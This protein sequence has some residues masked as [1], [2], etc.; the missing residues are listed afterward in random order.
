MNIGKIKQNQNY[1]IFTIILLSWSHQWLSI[2]SFINVSYN[3]FSLSSVLA[4]RNQSLS[5]FVINIFI[6]ILN[7]KKNFEN[8]IYFY[9]FLIPITY[10][11]GLFNLYIDTPN[12]QNMEFFYHF[13]FILQMI[14]TLLILNN[15]SKI[16]GIDQ[17]I[18]LKVNLLLIFIYIIIIFTTYD[19]SNLTF[20]YHINFLNQKILTN[21][22]GVSRILSIIS[23]FI[24]CYYFI[25][26]KGA[27]LLLII[28]F[29]IINIES[30]QGTILII[31]QLFIIIFWYHKDE[32]IKK[33]LQY[34]F[35]L[36]IIPLGLSLFLK[37]NLQKNR[38]F[39]FQGDLKNIAVL[40]D[41]PQMHL[42][43][44]DLK[45]IEVLKDKSEVLK[46]KSQ[47][48]LDMVKFNIFTTGRLE[49]WDTALTHIINSKIKNILFGNGPEFD[50]KLKTTSGGKGD[51]A[52]GILYTFLCGGLLGLLFFFILM[53]K[54]LKIILY[55]FYNKQKLNTDVYFCFSVCCII[56]LTLRSLIENGFHV[57][58]VDFLLI[59]SS[60]FYLIKKLKLI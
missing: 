58:G 9:F 39:M 27:Y 4:Y 55:A 3:N 10:L 20:Q 18:L 7:K 19:F 13:T 36:I 35:L 6:L 21:Q 11:L 17:T 57:Y 44:R 25:K 23:I 2:G 22:N 30:R 51:V 15:F 48:H 31:I 41:N 12:E 47:V 42:D 37:N 14:N 53:K 60:I 24:S 56:S 5:I 28:N 49:K 43:Q 29:L 38:L 52:N 8:R 16:V 26:K 40:K 50:R 1:I 33:F 34:F 59:T 46:D 54:I 32:L 45:N